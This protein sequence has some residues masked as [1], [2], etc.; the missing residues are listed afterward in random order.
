MKRVN[1]KF[2]DTHVLTVDEAF[3]FMMTG[4]GARPLAE[5]SSLHISEDVVELNGDVYFIYTAIGEPCPI[6][7]ERLAGEIP[8]PDLAASLIEAIYKDYE[9]PI[10]EH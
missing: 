5:F 4:E 3:N 1:G 7:I 2:Y 10:H 9:L 6:T 8:P